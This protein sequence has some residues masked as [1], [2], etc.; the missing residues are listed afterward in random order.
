MIAWLSQNAGTLAVAVIVL[1]VIGIAVWR[2]IANKRA[3]KSSCGC[4]C[5]GCAMKD[6]CHKK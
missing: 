1:A 2:V 5:S 6:Q 4:G 3:G